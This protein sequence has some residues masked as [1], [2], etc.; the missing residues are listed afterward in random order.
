MKRAL[1]SEKQ[2]CLNLI[3]IIAAFQVMFG[4][5][6]EHLKLPINDTFLESHFFQ[7]EFPSFL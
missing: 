5:L 6:V 2:N 7:G 1:T 4:H 3:R